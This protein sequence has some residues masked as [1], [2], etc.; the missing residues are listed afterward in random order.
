MVRMALM[1]IG[2]KPVLTAAR[3]VAALRR[4]TA[5]QA[6]YALLGMGGK[7]L[8]IIA[9]EIIDSSFVHR[10]IPSGH[11]FYIFYD[12]LVVGVLLIVF[13]TL[14]T[15]VTG[16]AIDG[17]AYGGTA[18]PCQR[19]DHLAHIL[20][21]MLEQDTTLR[22]AHRMRDDRQ[23][24][25]RGARVGGIHIQLE[26]RHDE[27]VIPQLVREVGRI[28]QQRIE[29]AHDGD[30]GFGLTGTLPTVLDLQQRIDHLMDMASVFGKEKFAAGRIIVLFH[31]GSRLHRSSKSPANAAFGRKLLIPNNKKR[32]PKRAVHRSPG[33]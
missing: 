6:L 29:I 17:S 22:I 8:F 7:V 13:V 23:I 20:A 12:H 3:I 21:V 26:I 1:S 2:L 27:K 9:S 14:G 31:N 11:Q 28:A 18:F 15:H 19:T 25:P 10:N 30:Y 33:I 5:G 32:F 4:R 16:Q 24:L